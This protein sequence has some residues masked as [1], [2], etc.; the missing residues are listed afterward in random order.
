M[1]VLNDL[2]LGYIRKKKVAIEMVFILTN[3]ITFAM[4]LYWTKRGFIE[5]LVAD[6]IFGSTFNGS[7]FA[8]KYSILKELG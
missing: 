3:S 4:S 8:Y 1:I 2:A 5:R 6:L 7:N